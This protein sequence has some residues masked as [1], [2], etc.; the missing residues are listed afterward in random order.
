M[1]R[2]WVTGFDPLSGKKHALAKELIVPARS[3]LILELMH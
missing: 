1:L 2:G 3:A